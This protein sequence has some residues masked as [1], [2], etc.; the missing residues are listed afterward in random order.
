M[1]TFCQRA[2]KVE[3][4]SADD[5]SVIILEDLKSKKKHSYRILDEAHDKLLA[6]D[7]VQGD[8]MKSVNVTE[9]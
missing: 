1:V 3:E 8:L 2:M 6:L 7:E 9:D 4:L 5:K